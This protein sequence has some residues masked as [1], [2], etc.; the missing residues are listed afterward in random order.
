[1]MGSI[2]LPTVLEQS[3][4]CRTMPQIHREH[5]PIVPIAN[6]V[7]AMLD[8]SHRDRMPIRRL[9]AKHRDRTRHV[10]IPDCCP[11]LVVM[12][13]LIPIAIQA[14]VQQILDDL[15]TIDAQ[16]VPQ[17]PR[18][19]AGT[20][21]FVVVAVVVVAAAGGVAVATR[22][23]KTKAA[24]EVAVMVLVGSRRWSAP[25]DLHLQQLSG[26]RFVRERRQGKWSTDGRFQVLARC[27]PPLARSVP[28]KRGVVAPWGRRARDEQSPSSSPVQC[29]W[30]KRHCPEGA[31]AAGVAT[32]VT[33]VTTAQTAQNAA[34]LTTKAA[35]TRL[36]VVVAAGHAVRWGEVE[37]APPCSRCGW[38]GHRLPT[39][40]LDFWFVS[41][42]VGLLVCLFVGL[43]ACLLGCDRRGVNV[44]SPRQS[45]L[46]SP[47]ILCAVAVAVAGSNHQG[48]R[49]TPRRAAKQTRSVRV[50]TTAAITVQQQQ[51]QTRTATEATA[52]A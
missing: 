38:L 20:V 46:E 25:P 2:L 22:Q 31:V 34:V 23:E 18:R 49:Q 48:K 8:A 21:D 33:A 17:H 37:A 19:V 16:T 45:S 41:L 28:E 7:V 13:D 14:I 10:A 42:L 9:F 50:T 5:F 24:A 29:W 6:L 12:Q 36:G 3:G 4:T 39:S 30:V 15:A 47:T 43:L 32:I 27:G 40:W 52:S 11:I 1:M 51:Q 44:L 26:P 35:K